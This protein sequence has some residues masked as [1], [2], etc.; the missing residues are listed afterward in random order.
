MTRQVEGGERFQAERVCIST[1]T[2]SW[3]QLRGEGGA[4]HE[5]KL[6]KQIDYQKSIHCQSGKRLLAGS[7]AAFVQ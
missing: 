1:R 5:S 2:L 4:S 6:G 3:C 7:A